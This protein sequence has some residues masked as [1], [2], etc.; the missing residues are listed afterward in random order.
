MNDPI[1]DAVVLG[2]FADLLNRPEDA[3]KAFSV[4]QKAIFGSFAAEQLALRQPVLVVGGTVPLDMPE[5]EVKRRFDI[6][7]R[8]FRILRCDLKYSLDQALD[9][10][11]QAL[12]A[13][14]SG[15]SFE[16]SPVG[17][18]WV[19]PSELVTAPV[20]LGRDDRD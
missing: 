5:R 18:G 11:P 8:W 15:K 3:R 10:L 19:Q 1:R 17:R 14:L 4:F 12:Q 9:T 16:P 6:C 13:E 7:E 2:P 20:G